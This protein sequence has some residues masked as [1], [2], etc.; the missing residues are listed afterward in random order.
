MES[1]SGSVFASLAAFKSFLQLCAGVFRGK[2]VA[3]RASKVPEARMRLT[4]SVKR[5][6]RLPKLHMHEEK[7]A[8][9]L[10]AHSST[11]KESDQSQK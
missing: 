3:K 1:S 6:N 4:N 5:S 11:D 7:S 10:G 2:V 9:S 8:I